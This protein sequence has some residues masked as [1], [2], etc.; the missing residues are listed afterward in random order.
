MFLKYSS[1]VSFLQTIE[2]KTL[3]KI[4]FSCWFD[5]FFSLADTTVFTTQTWRL[6]FAYQCL[7]STSYGR[8]R[9]TNRGTSKEKSVQEQVSIISVRQVDRYLALQLLT[10]VKKMEKISE[11]KVADFVFLAHVVDVMSAMHSP[12]VFRSFSS[13]PFSIKPF[14]FPMWPFTYLVMLLMWAKAKTFLF[15]LYYLRGK[16]HETWVVPRF[17]FQVRFNR[18][19]HKKHEVWSSY[20]L[21]VLCYSIFLQYFLPFATQG[22]NSQIEEAIL[23]AD[24]LGVKVISLAALNKVNLVS[25][26]SRFLDWGFSCVTRLILQNESLNG[27]G[28]LFTNKHPNLK[29]R[30]VHGNTLTAAVILHEIPRDVDEVFLT[31][32]T[33]KLGRAIALY[34]ARRKV[35]VLVCSSNF[36]YFC[37]YRY[38]KNEAFVLNLCLKFRC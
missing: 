36:S 8:R 20:C 12:F 35:K 29:V 21:I 7:C 30:V 26:T 38:I 34:L 37:F 33:S 6:T 3:W 23:K 32:A 27:G 11:S 17:G 13:T 5:F 9:T 31:G 2:E 14:L 28:T 24:K 22:I 25:S 15:S 18:S 1:I 10:L 19:E 4:T 16:L